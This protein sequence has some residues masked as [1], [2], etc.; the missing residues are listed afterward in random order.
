MIAPL[1]I[2]FQ[3][4]NDRATISLGE[5]SVADLKVEIIFL[6]SAED[7]IEFSKDL[8]FNIN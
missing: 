6:D 5:L 8:H 3:Q 4:D 2:I 1:K 7:C